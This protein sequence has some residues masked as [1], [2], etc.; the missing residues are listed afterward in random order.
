[1]TMGLPERLVVH[2]NG[3][4]LNARVH[5]ERFM[6]RGRE[7]PLNPELV[8]DLGSIAQKDDL[9]ITPDE[10]AIIRANVSAF[11]RPDEKGG[12]YLLAT[13]QDAV[14]NEYKAIISIYKEQNKGTLGFQEVEELPLSSPAANA[15]KKFADAQLDGTVVTAGELMA[16][17]D[18]AHAGGEK[19]KDAVV[20][21]YLTL[22]SPA[23]KAGE[24]PV[25]R[26]S[27][28]AQASYQRLVNEASYPSIIAS[29]RPPTE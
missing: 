23:E 21:N 12:V 4:E 7:T 28:D 13:N 8:K 18:A 27:P 20:N 3:A 5:G 26:A 2:P 14:K 22:F 19:G 1:M 15:N 9:Q 6:V 25:P 16:G 29:N 10:M 24:A 11:V 17:A